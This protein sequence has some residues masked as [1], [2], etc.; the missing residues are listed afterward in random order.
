MLKFESTLSNL[1]ILPSLT[2][3][4]EFFKKLL[5]FLTQGRTLGSK[6]YLLVFLACFWGWNTRVFFDWQWF[7]AFLFKSFSIK[8]PLFLV[9]DKRLVA[10]SYSNWLGRVYLHILINFIV[11]DDNNSDFVTETSWSICFCTETFGVL[12]LVFLPF[13]FLRALTFFTT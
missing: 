10:T 6:V 4:V 9:K 8:L 3:N 7:W 12:I 5:F 2:K 1:I 13:R 11:S